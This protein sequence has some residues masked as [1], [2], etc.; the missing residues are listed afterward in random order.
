MSLRHTSLFRRLCLLASCTVN[1]F[2]NIRL[3]GLFETKYTIS[4]GFPLYDVKYINLIIETYADPIH[5]TRKRA[6]Y[7]NA[8]N[9]HL[10]RYVP[11][12]K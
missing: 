10:A 3:D 4:I 9:P 8:H 6:R 2:V 5:L 12:Y 11:I 7:H 1:L